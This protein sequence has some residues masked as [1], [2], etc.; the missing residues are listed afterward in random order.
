[1]SLFLA[2]KVSFRVAREE[3]TKKERILIRYIYSFW[4]LHN[5]RPH[6]DWSLLG[7]KFK[8]SDEHPRPFHMGVPPPPRMNKI[9]PSTIAFMFFKDTTAKAANEDIAI[10]VK[11][12]QQ[13]C[14]QTIHF[15]A[16]DSHCRLFND[17]LWFRVRCF[18]VSR[19]L[20]DTKE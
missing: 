5:V 18:F 1:M 20:P 16:R 4:G 12:S 19:T 14:N 8:I 13:D 2:V 15:A 10:V 11:I 6:P 9:R 3:I 7:V 17:C